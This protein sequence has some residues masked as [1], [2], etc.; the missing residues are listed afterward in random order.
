MFFFGL[1]LLVFNNWFCCRSVIYKEQVRLNLAATNALMA[2]LEA[3]KAIC[4]GAEKDLHKKYKQRDDIEKQI[5]PEWEQG[6]KRSRIDYATLEER[7]SK[8]ALYL[9]GPRPR[10]PWHKEL[11]VLLEEEQRA[12]EVDY[13]ANEEQKQE[14]KEEKIKMPA[15]DDT[16]EK[17]EEHTTSGV[18]A[19]DEENSIEQRLEKLKIR[20]GKRSCGIS[21]TGLHETEIE[22]D[23][24]TR[25][26]RGKGNV[27]KW[28]QMLLENS[29]QPGTDP[30]ETNENASH[31]IEEKIIQQLNQKFPQK[32][33][34]ISKVSD[35]DYE[36]K[37]L[38][39][40]ED[41]NQED[42]IENESSSVL[43]TG[44]KNYS[45]EACIGEGNCTPNVE[46]MEKKE[47]HKKEKRLLPRSES[48]KTLRRIPSSPSLLFG[49][50][51]GVDCIR[52]KPT[53]SDD[54]AASNSFLRS[55]FKT[56][57]KAVN[58]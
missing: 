32:E 21:F 44:H 17:L 9:P 58:L 20:E 54:L 10:T 43:P 50:R 46:G 5:R 55:S 52:K 1:Q 14:D 33:L 19:L 22:E 39:L 41:K 16:E 4:D 7:E 47:E 31:R 56:I 12:S 36:E 42:T 45:E 6:R 8:P 13:S 37:Q 3:Q 2:R 48:A 51:K 23:E 25:K 29:P 15:K 30:E 38:Q 18:V 34:K 27:E 40:L 35:S 57:K 28:L 11:R 24:E 49:I 53:A 26:Q